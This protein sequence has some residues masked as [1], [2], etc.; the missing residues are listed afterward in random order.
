MEPKLFVFLCVPFARRHRTPL[1]EYQIFNPNSHSNPN[2]NPDV[3][4]WAQ[5][6]PWTAMNTTSTGGLPIYVEP[7]R[8]RY[9]RGWS[10]RTVPQGRG[11]QR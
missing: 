5:R 9:Q 11:A 7:I 10:Q 6:S 8:V 2:A 1:A 4:V 3:R